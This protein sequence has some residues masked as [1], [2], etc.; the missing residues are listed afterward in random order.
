MHDLQNFY[1][2][3]DELTDLDSSLDN[4]LLYQSDF[5]VSV[6]ETDFKD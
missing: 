6:S 3:D 4:S 1:S 5:N 2:K